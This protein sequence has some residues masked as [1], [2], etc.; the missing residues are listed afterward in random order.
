MSVAAPPK[1]IKCSCQT[2]TSDEFNFGLVERKAIYKNYPEAL[3]DIPVVDIEAIKDETGFIDQFA[4]VLNLNE[5]EEILS[6]ITG[7]VLVTTGYDNYIPAEGEYGYVTNPNVIT[8]PE[9]KRLIELFPNKL[10]YNNKT[11]NS[12]AF[13]Y[14]VGNRQKKGDNKYC[15]RQCC[16]STIHT[17][18]QLKEK[19]LYK[20]LPVTIIAFLLAAIGVFVF[21]SEQKFDLHNIVHFGH[22]FEAIAILSVF[23]IILLPNIVR[24]W[25]FTTF[26]KTK[27]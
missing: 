5:K 18:M 9:L 3:P 23:V 19:L 4:S 12:I 7:A 11:I 16:S 14:C 20:S 25:W 21:A 10:V 6:L 24:M 13:I 26:S 15:S 8:L 27:K 1:T 22:Q 17:S 2:K